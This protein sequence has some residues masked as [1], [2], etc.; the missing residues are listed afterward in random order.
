MKPKNDDIIANMSILSACLVVDAFIMVILSH[1]AFF[2]ESVVGMRIR[3]AV[4]SL[5]YRK[6]KEFSCSNKNFNTG[7]IQTLK[8]TETSLR[9][10]TPGQ[11]VNLLSNDVS[12]FDF[13]TLSLQFLWIFP[14]PIIG[15]MYFLWNSFGISSL[16]GLLAII[17]LTIPVQGKCIPP[18][19]N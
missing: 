14:F 4:S 10:T 16:V 18:E 5:V 15:C 12:R 11:I 9:Q 19:P 3:V 8:L 2:G 17:V 1:H 6:V 7:P 13:V